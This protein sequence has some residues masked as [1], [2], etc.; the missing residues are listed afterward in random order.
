MDAIAHHGKA[1]CV[2]SANYTFLRRVVAIVWP[3]RKFTAESR[4][5]F[6]SERGISTHLNDNLQFVS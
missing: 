1:A 3:A 4:R 2:Q 5:K 6:C